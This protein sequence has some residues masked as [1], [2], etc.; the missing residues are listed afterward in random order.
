MNLTLMN[1]EASKV[2][3]LVIHLSSEEKSGSLKTEVVV[4]PS[5]N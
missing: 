3:T 2:S 4:I 1:H 5:L